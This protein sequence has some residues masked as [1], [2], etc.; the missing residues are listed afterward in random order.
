MGYARSMPVA[1]K[2][3]FFSYGKMTLTALALMEAF[4]GVAFLIAWRF[5][6]LRFSCLILFQGVLFYFW[7]LGRRRW[8]AKG[9]NA[10]IVQ[11][12]DARKGNR[13][14]PPSP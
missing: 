14:G 1:E 2:Q 13:G 9:G 12:F 6:G 8:Q 3:S 11:Y 7:W 10:Q 5:G 4:V